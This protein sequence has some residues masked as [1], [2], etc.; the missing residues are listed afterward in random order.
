MKMALIFG[1]RAM[2][3]NDAT[4][5]AEKVIGQKFESR[6]NGDFGN[7]SQF[8]ENRFEHLRIIQNEDMYDGEVLFTVAKNW[9]YVLLL[10]QAPIGSR[11]LAALEAH[12]EHFVK[13]EAKTY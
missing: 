9:T 11:Y 6:N 5:L 3:L 12:S 10:E 13:L 4:L 1:V 8:G 7:Y 2:S